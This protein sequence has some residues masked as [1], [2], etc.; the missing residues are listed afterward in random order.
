[1]PPLI[2]QPLVENAVYHGIQ[3]SHPP[4]EIRI[5]AATGAASSI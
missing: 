5:V 2:L 3:P 4:G 1:M